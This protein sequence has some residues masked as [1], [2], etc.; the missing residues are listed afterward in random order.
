MVD[1]QCCKGM[2]LMTADL[3]LLLIDLTQEGGA[4]F[5]REGAAT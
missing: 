1:R 5:Q 4:I 3:A 2:F